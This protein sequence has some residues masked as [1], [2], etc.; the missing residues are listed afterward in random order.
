MNYIGLNRKTTNWRKNKMFKNKY[1]S[2][3]KKSIKNAAWSYFKSD[4]LGLKHYKNVNEVIAALESGEKLC[5]LVCWGN[6]EVSWGTD[7]L[8][9]WVNSSDQVNI[10]PSV[11]PTTDESK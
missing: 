4:Q 6:G 11:S 9:V 1:E 8:E 2:N 3:P 7:R 5:P 10:I